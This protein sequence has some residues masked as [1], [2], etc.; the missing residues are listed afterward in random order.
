MLHPILVRFGVRISGLVKVDGDP[1]D[2]TLE[3]AERG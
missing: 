3:A 1:I 2:V